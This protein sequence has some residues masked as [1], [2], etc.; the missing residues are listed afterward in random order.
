MTVMRYEDL[1]MMLDK[2]E[3]RG[4]IKTGD[5]LMYFVSPFLKSLGYNVFDIDEVD[6]QQDGIVKVQVMEG[7]ELVVTLQGNKIAEKPD[8]RILLRIDTKKREIKLLFKVLGKWETVDIVDLK[9][10]DESSYV[11][12]TKKLVKE[13]LIQEYEN[14]GERFLTE[15]VLDKQLER[16]E[17]DN[18]F[19]RYSFIAELEEPSDLFVELL[20]RRLKEEFTTHEVE[21]IQK[22]LE[23]MQVDGVVPFVKKVIENMDVS[24]GKLEQEKQLGAS[25]NTVLDVDNIEDKK[26]VEEIKEQKVVRVEEEEITDK[27]Q[28]AD[29]ADMF[30]FNKEDEEE[31]DEKK[32]GIFGEELVLDTGS[33]GDKEKEQDDKETFAGFNF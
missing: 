2:L 10:E 32:D 1:K 28:V 21:W 11:E 14:K 20:A 15:I 7:I 8:T 26:E 6:I 29:L 17:W 31:E 22:R 13:Q 24:V 33:D 25:T 5:V 4:S 12:V 27:E 18:D 3:G 16:G 30:D 23:T 19:L 9:G